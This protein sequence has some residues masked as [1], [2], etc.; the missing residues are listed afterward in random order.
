M[1]RLNLRSSYWCTLITPCLYQVYFFLIWNYK[2]ENI[3]N[4]INYI[5]DYPINYN[6]NNII[7]YTID[8][9]IGYIQ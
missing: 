9:I 5:I 6:I 1:S 4:M 8:N 2:I 3:E 7:Y